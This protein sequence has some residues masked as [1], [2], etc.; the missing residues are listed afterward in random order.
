MAASETVSSTEVKPPKRSWKNVLIAPKFQLKF[1]AWFSLHGVVL[2]IFYNLFVGAFIRK[3]FGLILEQSPFAPSQRQEVL[4]SL[5][6]LMLKVLLVSGLFVLFSAV[7]GLMFSHRTSGPL[8]NLKRAFRRI[9]NGDKGVRCQFRTHDELQDVS[10][11]FNEMMESLEQR[12]E[13]NARN[14]S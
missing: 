9:K 14:S 7:A 2:G 11:E 4:V 13:S 3:S 12:A 6:A 8:Y 1:V 10:T 5:D